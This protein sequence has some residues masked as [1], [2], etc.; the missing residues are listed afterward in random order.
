[1]LGAA[2]TYNGTTTISGGVLQADSGTGLPTASF[3]ALDGGVLQA[4]SST[5]ATF[6][7][8]L[9]TSGSGKF[10]WTANGG[11]FAAGAGSL[12]VA[13]NL[14]SNGL[15]G[16][17][18]WGTMPGTNIVGT[19]MFGST[20][21]Q[22]ATV[23]CNPVDLAGADRT[24]NVD[25][26]PLTTGDY[27]L[28]SGFIMNHIG[29]AGL[30]K[31]GNGLLCLTGSNNYNGSTTVSAGTLKV[32][33]TGGWATGSG[34]VVVNSGAN[35]V[36]VGLY[37]GVGHH[38]RHPPGNSPRITGDLRPDHIPAQFDVQGGGIRFGRRNRIRRTDHGLAGVA[39]RFAALD[40]RQFYAHWQ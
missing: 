27:T 35:A 40:F 17:L 10:E 31:T 3:L 28:L 39:S 8:A 30:I 12:T 11:G 1:M 38:C 16:M 33:N 20:T 13:L 19:L 32:A 36:R 9:S 21:S 25:D 24:I 18:T 7:Y 34:A 22:N 26:N 29:V 37:R 5:A 6:N 23:F 15:P 14:G 2:N 4:N